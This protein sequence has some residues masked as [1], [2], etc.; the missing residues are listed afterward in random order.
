VEEKM[1]RVVQ[2]LSWIALVGAVLP[3]FLFLA[4]TVELDSAKTLTLVAT[5]AWFVFTPLW[6]GRETRQAQP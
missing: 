2:L 4:G 3:S 1:R 6:M 5:I